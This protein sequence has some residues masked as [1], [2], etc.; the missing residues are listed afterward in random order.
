MR[1]LGWG[2]RGLALLVVVVLATGLGLVAAVTGRGLPQTSGTV[3]IEGL[4]APVTVIR[5][6]AGILQIRA[7]DPHD[8]FLA[9]GYVHAQERMWQMEV[10]RHIGAGR[11]SELFGSS[12]LERDRFIRTLGWR[13]AA[14]RDLDAMPPDV[15][16]ALDAYAD[17]VNA[18]LADHEGAFG[19]P[20]VVTGLL[21]GTGGA[22]GYTPE[23][24]TPL[25]SA[26]WQKVQAWNLGGN[27]NGEIFRL[28]AD[29]RL[30]DPAR[31]DSLFP[32]YDADAPVIT[33]SGL[34]ATGGGGATGAAAAA[35]TTPRITAS[36]G[37]A[38]SAVAPI[39]SGAPIAAGAAAAWH[40]LADL[41]SEI[42]TLA[43]LDGGS[44]LVGGHGIGSNNW[45]I[46]GSKSAT[47]G[48]LLANDPHLGFSMPSI[49]IMNGLH[50]RVVDEA[51]PF[52]VAGVSFPGVP[53][54]VL[55]H[56]AR[57]AWGATNVGPDVQDL[58]REKIDPADPK[59]YL[60][61]GESIPFD[62]R[63]ETIR[64]AGGPDEVIEVRSTRHGPIL[65]D[66]EPR[67]ADSPPIAL[68]WT[69]I[70]EADGALTS[71]FR[72]NTVRNFEDFRAAFEGYG[73]PSQ[74]FVYADVDG[75]IGYQLPGLIPVR[76][77]EPTGARVRDG[78]SGTEEWSGYI[79]FEDLPW[80]FDP[81]SGVIV[82]A[83][84]AAVDDAYPYYI[85]EDWDPG[86]RARRITGLL[87]AAPART[88][89][90]ARFRAMQMDAYVLRADRIIP[91]VVAEA[92]PR[93]EDGR[94]LLDRIAA[95]D[96]TCGVDSTGCAAYVATEFMLTRAIF[97]DELGPLAK[98]YVGTPPSWQALIAVLADPSSPWWDDTSTAGALRPRDVISA[99]VDRTA[100]DLRAAVGSPARWTWGRLH[101]V[102]FAE[103]TLGGSGIGPLSWYFNSGERPVAGANGAVNNNYY[104]TWRAFPDPD[105]PGHVPAGLDSVFSVSNGPSYRLTI[106]LSSL[107]AA[108]IV[109]TSGQSGNPFDRHYGDLIDDWA[110]GG[111]VPLPFS[112]DAIEASAASELTLVP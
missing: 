91:G 34:A 64:V 31:T 79:P 11:L 43:G 6:R 2:L 53:A 36:V 66:V 30:G 32:P 101:R 81:P 54:I 33:P 60:F 103:Q 67:L 92:S 78:A 109:I 45:V 18:W 13:A 83:N 28:L 111:T 37:S 94:L 75:H 35:T 39:A 17:G 69:S 8:L 27:W 104:Q 63:T 76:A 1:I 73:S 71:I 107:D 61:N 95:W 47:G 57:V 68:Q 102:N 9:Q 41:G 51:C 87:E 88:L 108:R 58:Y 93:T 62:V 50:C 85:A 77:G 97:E 100:A 74:N 106:D 19:P 105:D 56:N 55:G 29:V 65:N 26:T 25:D 10:W 96:R 22:G 84:N 112:W 21:A 23:P 70:H 3:R 48:A 98:D 5:D 4:H 52:D 110:S 24:W 80:Q 46:A 82:T 89:T 15:R 20:F 90:P 44:G 38:A 59:R 14:Q 99:V 12:S 7:G 49:W 40:D 42:L 72:L 16:A 86:Y